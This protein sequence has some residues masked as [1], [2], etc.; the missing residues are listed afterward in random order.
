MKAL[1][2]IKDK[3]IDDAA[4]G[5]TKKLSTAKA[6]Y[7]ITNGKMETSRDKVKGYLSATA[8]LEEAQKSLEYKKTIEDKENTNYA[9]IAADMDK[10]QKAIIAAIGA[11]GPTGLTKK[12]TDAQGVL[13]ANDTLGLKKTNKDTDATAKAAKKLYAAEIPKAKAT[14]SAM[15]AK[16]KDLEKLLTEAKALDAGAVLKAQGDYDNWLK[17]QVKEQGEVALKEAAKLKKIVE[18]EALKYNEYA[19]A[20]ADAVSARKEKIGKIVKLLDDRAKPAKG[21]AGW[22]CEKALSN[23]TFRPAR[24]EKTCAEGLCC[25]A[26]KYQDGALMMTIETCQAKATT[27]YEYVK[28]RTPLATDWK[29]VPNVP[30]TCI[31]GAQKLVSAASALAAAVYMMA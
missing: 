28:A 20:L 22:R 12:L 15:S 11:V 31:S 19:K 1:K 9:L 30:F 6:A 8:V 4:T 25:G 29:K 3:A 21:A 27:T 26:A 14:A 24:N 18:C 17:L 5:F 7:D 10:Q 2:V 16:L 23:G 13:G